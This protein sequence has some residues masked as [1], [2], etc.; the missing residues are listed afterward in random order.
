MLPNMI[1]FEEAELKDFDKP[2]R[3][4]VQLAFA[5]MKIDALSR[6]DAGLWQS[7]TVPAERDKISSH[8]K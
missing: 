4:F 3:R 1:H 5:P 2:G 6:T 8:A 7:T